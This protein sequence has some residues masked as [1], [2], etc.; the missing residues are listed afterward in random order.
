MWASY[1]A[2]FSTQAGDHPS[3]FVAA[4][5]LVPF[6]YGSY[7]FGHWRALQLAREFQFPEPSLHAVHTQIFEQAAFQQ[8][9][10]LIGKTSSSGR[11]SFYLGI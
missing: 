4:L 2:G 3:V 10:D 8:K 11:H 6:V 7:Y 5:A 9:S 1:S